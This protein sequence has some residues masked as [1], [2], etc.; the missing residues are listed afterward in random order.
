MTDPFQALHERLA[1]LADLRNVAQ[2]LDWDQQTMMPPRGAPAR[3]ETVATVQRLSHEMF[4]SDETG[5][6]L[7]AA[8][9]HLEALRPTRTMRLSS[10][11]PGANGTRRGA[12]LRSSPPTW[13]ARHRSVTRHG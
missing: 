5:R 10:G 2:L 12:S 11:S 3:A 4:V 1:Q 7:E 8:A 9:A 13:R 6:L